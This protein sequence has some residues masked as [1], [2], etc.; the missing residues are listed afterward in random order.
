MAKYSYLFRNKKNNKTAFF[1]KM[2]GMKG[3]SKGILK[4]EGKFKLGMLPSGGTGLIRV[5]KK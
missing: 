3:V 2:V 4:F 1:P 5:D